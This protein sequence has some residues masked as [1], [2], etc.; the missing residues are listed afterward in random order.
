MCTH[1]CTHTH[2]QRHRHVHTHMIHTNRHRHIHTCMCTHSLY[3][4]IYFNL[5]NGWATHCLISTT[6]RIYLPLIILNCSLLNSVF[7]LSW[8]TL[9]L[10]PMPLYPVLLGMVD[11]L[12]STLPLHVDLPLLLLFIFLPPIPLSQALKSRSLASVCPAQPLA[13]DIFIYQSELTGDRVPQC[14]TCRDSCKH[15]WGPKLTLGQTHYK[16]D[17]KS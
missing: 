5:H 15:S 2:T 17:L 12:S 3:I 16:M 7:Y 13:A 8:A 6:D 11:L 14:L 10:L 1:T 9:R 4:L